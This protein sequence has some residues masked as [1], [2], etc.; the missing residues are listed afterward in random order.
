MVNQIKDTQSLLRFI[1]A[2]NKVKYVFFW[3]HKEAGEAVTKACLSQWYSALFEYKGQ[4]YKTA[5]HFMMVEKAK[6]FNDLEKVQEMLDADDPGKVKSIGRSVRNFNQAIWDESKIEIAIRGNFEKFKQN[7]KLGE[8]LVNT[9]ERILVEASPVDKV[10]GVG[11]EAKDP[12]IEN[13]AHWLGQ[14][15]LGF[16]LM[17]VRH[18]LGSC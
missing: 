16:S 4:V 14:N 3:G 6:L 10:W 5:E 9:K 7:E 1:N 18:R 13:P 8:F 12:L 17:Q 15:L 11:L 2:E